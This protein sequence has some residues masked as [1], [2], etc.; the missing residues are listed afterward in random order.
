MQDLSS[1]GTRRRRMLNTTIIF[2][3]PFG[4]E[5]QNSSIEQSRSGTQHGDSSKDQIRSSLTL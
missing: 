2:L 4:E 3:M 5:V 1:T